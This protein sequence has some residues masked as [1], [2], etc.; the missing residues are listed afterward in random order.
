M[1]NISITMT[2]NT[3]NDNASVIRNLHEAPE[4]VNFEKIE[5]ELQEIKSH[6][7]KGS[8]EFEAVETLERSSKAHNW[9]A[10]CSTIGKFASQFAGAT[11]S[12]LAGSYLSNLLGLGH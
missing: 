5:K 3:L 2:N 4:G 9:G 6:L 12:S 7:K 10:I 8:P 11:L 1:A